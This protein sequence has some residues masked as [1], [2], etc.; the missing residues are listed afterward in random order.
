MPAL[1]PVP[2]ALPSDT[3]IAFAEATAHRL[4]ATVL[5]AIEPLAEPI[6]VDPARA[7][8]TLDRMI[9]TLIGCAIGHALAPIIAVGRRSARTAGRAFDPVAVLSRVVAAAGT[10]IPA[11]TH[12]PVIADPQRRPLV[13]ELGA[14][15]HAR[16]LAAA[17]ALAAGA[18]ALVTAAPE[19]GRAAVRAAVERAIGDDLCALRFADRIVTGWAALVAVLAGGEPPADR[20]W[21]PWVRRVRG[22]RVV[23]PVASPSPAEGIL[24]V[25]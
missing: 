11:E 2:R 17:G 19:L 9:E 18:H 14:R 4:A 21:Q 15:L 12:A 1:R 16:M 7:L 6:G 22:E 24:R 13:D 23:A 10:G 3:E 25:A 5:V 20:L 8:A